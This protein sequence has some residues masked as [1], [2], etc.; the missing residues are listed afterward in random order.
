MVSAYPLSD[1][2]SLPSS[3]E[4][5]LRNPEE[6]QLRTDILAMRKRGMSYCQ[7]EREVS[8]HWTRLR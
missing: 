4:S 1:T 3:T 5:D 2:G 6:T 8:L 7:V